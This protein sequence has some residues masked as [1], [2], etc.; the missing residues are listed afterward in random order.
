MKKLGEAGAVI[1]V[2]DGYARNY[3][4]PKNLAVL[5][6]KQNMSKIENIKKE[7]EAE[8]LALHNKYIAIVQQITE[9]G[10]VTFQ[11]KA[12]E[13]EHLFGSVSEA[14]IAKALAEKGIE[15]SK[16]FISMEKHLKEIGSFD[17]EVVFTP[18]IKAAL[19]V[20]IDKE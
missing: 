4:L 19:K 5:A 3:L 15:I 6:T 8:K 9:V 7:A 14:D 13:N 20:T 2:A 16:A 12:D 11:R 17:V 1:N 10:E 18:E